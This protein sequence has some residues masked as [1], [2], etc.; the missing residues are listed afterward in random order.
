MFST[1]ASLAASFVTAI[2]AGL[3]AALQGWTYWFSGYFLGFCLIWM[4]ICKGYRR[5]WIP[6]LQYYA[7]ALGTCAMLVAPFVVMMIIRTQ[8]D[9][10]PGLGNMHGG[11]N[12]P[13]GF[14]R[15]HFS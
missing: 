13:Q 12:L 14:A 2:L 3:F 9:E 6:Y 1:V 11:N 5:R 8:G 4:A 15:V 10:I 7:V